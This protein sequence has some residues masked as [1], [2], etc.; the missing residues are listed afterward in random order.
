MIPFMGLQAH[1]I[2]FKLRRI[3]MKLSR[4]LLS[5]ALIMIIAAG[6]VF[7]EGSSQPSSQSQ[8]TVTAYNLP[9]NQTLYYNGLQW[10]AALGNNPYMAN[11][12]NA[13]A[14]AA[15][16]QLVYETL[17]VYNLLDGKLYPQIG[18]SYTWNG[19]TLTV[20]LNPNVRFS[21]GSRLTSADVVYS[22]EIAK[23]YTMGFTAT[24]DYLDSVT[25]Q[26]DYTVIIR[27]KAP[28][29]FNMKI[30][31]QAISERQITSKAY[32]DSKIASGELSRDPSAVLAFPGWDC[33]GSGPYVPMFNDNTKIVIQRNDNYWGQHASRYGKL[34][35]P[36]YI[37]HNIYRDNAAGDEAMRRGEVDM[38][39]QF[40]ASV[41][42]YPNVET[43]VPV[44]PYYIPGVI[45]SIIFNTTRPGLDD[46]NVRKAL[47]MVINYD[48]IGTNAMSG[49]TAP[50]QHHLMLP[51]P[52]EQ[53]LIDP[54]QLR[55]YQW[56]GIDVAGAN[57]ILDQAGWVRGGDGIR[58]KGGV[59]LSFRLECP[60][61]WSDWN[62]SLEV[63][64]QA[65][66]QIGMDLT[67]YFPD[68]P[69]YNN[70]LQT[71]SFDIIMNSPG[72]QGI[73]SPWTRARAVMDSSYL[74]PVGTPNTIGNYGRWVNAE[75]TQLVDQ[76]KNETNA[77]TLVQLWTRLNI[78]YLD[79]M[80]AI[81]LM[82]RP[83][84]FHQVSTSVW[85]GFPRLND[86]TNIPP[87]LL[88][89][90]YGIRGLYNLRLR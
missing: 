80:P 1:E 72:G 3:R 49:Y 24:W 66:A 53:A 21:D 67:T 22:F 7:A 60:Q 44:A 58:A 16:R 90:G 9:R 54:A 57:R 4:L 74:P 40:M 12:N 51:S 32:W 81:G 45:P 33:I 41:W 15:H 78:I 25:A 61:G 65:G 42:T 31:E 34:P 28:P 50:K 84:V 27:A 62:A 55:Q 10:S 86:G 18:D 39:Q 87:T 73:A 77:A 71:A 23:T 8:G 76:I 14:I 30:V 29:N 20:Q 35:T 63:V 64:A 75:A 56:E 17:F 88:S 11:P 79:E 38:S 83:W 82:Y 37:A 85:T 48:L 47:A 68:T 6:A 2:K 46:K 43:Y 5:L 19:Q 13:L 26:G 36:R 70:D 52:A 89:D 59:R 69:V